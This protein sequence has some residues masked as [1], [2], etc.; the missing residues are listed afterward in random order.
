MCERLPIYFEVK[1][2]INTKE[3]V[4]NSILNVL[5]TKLDTV[6]KWTLVQ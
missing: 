3:G 6:Q 1:K 5:L 4:S 2:V